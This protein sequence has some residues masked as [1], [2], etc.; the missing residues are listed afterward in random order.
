MKVTLPLAYQIKYRS[1]RG[2]KTPP[3]P[4]HVW[5]N[6]DFDIAS[7]NAVDTHFVAEWRQVYGKA[8]L[9]PGPALVGNWKYDLAND[10]SL[11]RLV[12]I[13]GQF[14]LPVRGVGPGGFGVGPIGM[15]ADT[16]A[17][18]IYRTKTK[19]AL[20]DQPLSDFGYHRLRQAQW[21]PNAVGDEGSPDLRGK[22]IDFDDYA[23]EH[24]NLK[25]VLET[26]AFVDGVLF[27]KVSEPVIVIA[28]S[29]HDGM[30]TAA[31]KIGERRDYAWPTREQYFPLT[32]FELA[33]RH[34]ADYWPDSAM[35]AKFSDLSVFIQEVLSND[36]E[37]VEAERGVIHFVEETGDV[38]RFLDRHDA[39][40]WF[41]L[42][43][44]L[45]AQP[46]GIDSDAID[47][48]SDK[49]ATFAQRVEQIN[50]F[51]DDKK[52]ILRFGRMVAERWQLRVIEETQD[53]KI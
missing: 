37:K 7:Y 9:E 33:K 38:L 26:M 27:H 53:F 23:V 31:L 14:Y 40:I 18:D 47:T 21:T 39:D 30:E 6:V 1:G 2:A 16:M 43:D 3:A 51:P 15:F 10:G 19:F 28:V 50:D 22:A 13:D 35:N 8:A 44:T 32:Q 12:R 45:R 48:M 11:A 36:L 4:V 34:L 17:E 20:G 41:D 29:A 52:Q 42:R 5:K 46:N 49:I 25:A 24:R